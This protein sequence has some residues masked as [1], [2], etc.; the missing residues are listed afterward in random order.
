MMNPNLFGKW[1]TIL[2]REKG[3]HNFFKPSSLAEESGLRVECLEN[4]MA[5]RQTEGLHPD[6]PAN[7][8]QPDEPANQQTV[9][10]EETEAADPTQGDEPKE[11]ES[12]REP[13]PEDF[14]L[15]QKKE[16]WD[17]LYYIGF[18]EYFMKAIKGLEYYDADQDAWG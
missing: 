10:S 18:I 17:D 14:N 2:E 9:E 15:P 16:E 12:K 5:P 3:Q 4:E 11:E 7:Q 13:K 1:I 6:E 8:L